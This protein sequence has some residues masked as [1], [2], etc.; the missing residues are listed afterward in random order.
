MNDATIDARPVFPV[1]DNSPWKE[2]ELTRDRF[3]DAI[4]ERLASFD[5]RA[6]VSRSQ[7]GEYPI[8]LFMQAWQPEEAGAE[9]TV[10]KRQALAI[11]IDVNP[12][13]E[14]PLIFDISVNTGRRR[15]KKE[16]WTLT[17]TDARD[18][19]DFALGKGAKPDVLKVRWG[20]ILLGITVVGAFFV[21]KNKLIKSARPS[22]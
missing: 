1:N 10:T 13:L 6:Q 21:K 5:I 20:D 17:D 9:Q 19:T 12:Y 7:P 11:A 16:S 3:A 15:Y 18:L 22:F 4:E 8:R 14:N 2:A